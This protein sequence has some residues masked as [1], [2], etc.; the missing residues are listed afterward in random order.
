M[1]TMLWYS[2]IV[3]ASPDGCPACRFLPLERHSR[4]LVLAMF[5]R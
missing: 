2:A 1:V 5:V 4:P 3:E